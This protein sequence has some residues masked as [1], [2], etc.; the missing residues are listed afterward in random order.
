MPNLRKA[1]L[2]YLLAVAACAVAFAAD[3]LSRAAGPS[4]APLASGRPAGSAGVPRDVDL[5]RLRRQIREGFLSDRK[6]L[7]AHPLR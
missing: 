5:E 7:H 2:A 3:V 1:D 6:A 4:A